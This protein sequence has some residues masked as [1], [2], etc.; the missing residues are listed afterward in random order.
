[1]RKRLWLKTHRRHGGRGLRPLRVRLGAVLPRRHRH[2]AALPVPRQ[3]ERRPRPRPRSSSPSRTSRSRR[4][5]ASTLGAWWVPAAGRARHGGDGPRPQ[6]LADRDGEE[7]AVPGR[8]RAG[9]RCCSTCAATAPRGRTTSF[10]A[11][12]KLDVARRPSTGA[13]SA[14]PGPVV[15]WGVSL[16]AASPRRWPRPRRPRSRRSSATRRTAA[17]ADTVN[18]HLQLAR[19]L[20]LVAAH[21][22][23]WPVGDIVLFWMRQ[24]AGFDPRPSTWSPR[25]A[26]LQGRPGAVRGR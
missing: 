11:A 17:L 26:H 18:H 5:T 6:P 8:A 20:A 19:G 3:G 22:A 13:G 2:H 9:T 14:T 4:A 15:L 24:R 1:M 21:R 25:A 10:G 12:E 7:G 16:G 23:E